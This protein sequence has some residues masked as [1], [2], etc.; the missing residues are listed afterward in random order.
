M[1]GRGK[2]PG[3][4]REQHD[5]E[6]PDQVE[7]PQPAID[8]ADVAEGIV[9][10]APRGGDHREADQEGRVVTVLLPGRGPQRRRGVAGGNRQVDGQQSDGDGDH[11]VGEQGDPF[12]APRIVFPLVVRHQVIMTATALTSNGNPAPWSGEDPRR[13]TTGR[14]RTEI[15][16]P[17]YLFVAF[18]YLFRYEKYTY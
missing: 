8:P 2:Q 1:P 5:R 6:Q 16:L 11:G 12:G 17:C 10:S 3:R 7:L 14:A 13:V 4:E 15:T 18:Q 9:V